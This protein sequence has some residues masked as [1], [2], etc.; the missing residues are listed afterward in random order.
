MVRVWMRFGAGIGV[1]LV[2]VTGLIM[3]LPEDDRTLAEV[4]TL[5]FPQECEAPCM[6]GL[7][8]GQ[9][10]VS[11]AINHLEAHPWV[12]NID[13]SGLRDFDGTGGV[14]LGGTLTW[15]WS[16]KQPSWISSFSRGSLIVR[17]GIVR[18]VEVQTLLS[19][20]EIWQIFGEPTFGSMDPTLRVVEQPQLRHYAHY[21]TDGFWVFSLAGCPLNPA[22]FWTVPA[23]VGIGEMP[24]FSMEN[25][26]LGRWFYRP[27]R[28][29]R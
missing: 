2:I 9:T 6:M 17:E 5:L 26:H 25:Y 21:E 22:T 18:T 14:G 24:A 29:K 19:Y 20:G 23:A 4:R 8:P 3:A 12:E 27:P 28:C 11:A 1:M 7:I 16:G 15:E 13:R 10:E